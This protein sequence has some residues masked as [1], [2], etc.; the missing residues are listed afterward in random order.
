MQVWVR[1][2]NEGRQKSEGGS[3]YEI[4]E[5]HREQDREQSRG[6]GIENM[7]ERKKEELGREIE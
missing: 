3:E 5:K 4:R 6:N 7:T 2:L 1:F